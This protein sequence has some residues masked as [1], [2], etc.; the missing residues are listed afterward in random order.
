MGRHPCQDPQALLHQ[1]VQCLNWIWSCTVQVGSG[2]RDKDQRGQKFRLQHIA[3]L[4]GT[5]VG[6]IIQKYSHLS[7][8]QHYSFKQWLLFHR[9]S[10]AVTPNFSAMVI[11]TWYVTPYISK[12]TSSF[13][14]SSPASPVFI[15]EYQFNHP[16]EPPHVPTF[17]A[18]DFWW[19]TLILFTYFI[20]DDK[21][22]DLHV[23][24]SHKWKQMLC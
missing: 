3:N 11:L 2:Q 1:H 4:Q 20:A 21:R 10:S 14:N 9:R 18:L 17:L 24:S 13:T 6:H 7:F 22:L 16:V 5:R 19:W 15:Q 8:R 23:N 12:I